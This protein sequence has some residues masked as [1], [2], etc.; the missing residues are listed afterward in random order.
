[1]IDKV[2][3]YIALDWNRVKKII[4]QDT[5][6][7]LLVDVNG[8]GGSSINQ[9]LGLLILTMATNKSIHASIFTQAYINGP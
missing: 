5:R 7:V 3:P 8:V 9:R 4:I 6:P 2:Q 1:M